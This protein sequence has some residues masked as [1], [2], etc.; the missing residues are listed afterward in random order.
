MCF[1][2]Y[3]VLNEFDE[4]NIVQSHLFLYLFS[5]YPHPQFFSTINRHVLEKLKKMDSKF[6][7]RCGILP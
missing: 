3:C 7:V 2:F 4:I 1:C 6:E 5:K